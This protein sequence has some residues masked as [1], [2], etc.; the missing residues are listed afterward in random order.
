[1]SPSL[2]GLAAPF[3]AFGR[4]AGKHPVAT[5]AT[6]ATVTHAA[7]VTAVL[8]VDWPEGDP[9]GLR[10]AADAL[11]QLAKKIDDGLVEADEAARLVWMDH[12]GP[13]V[14]AFKN[15]WRGTGSAPSA[16]QRPDGFSGYPPDV[17]DYSRRVAAA[18]RAYADN[19]ETIR[20]VLV[21]MAIQAWVNM[22]FTTMYAWPTAGLGTLAERAVQ[23]Y[24]TSL[25]QSQ[26]KIFGLS[27]QKVVEGAFYYTI[28]SVAYAGI[29]QV[30]KAGVYAASGVRKDQN[31]KD[32]LSF[33]TNAVE[34]AQGFGANMAFNAAGD[35]G[36][37]LPFVTKN[38]WWDFVRRMGGSATYSI[39]DNFEQ[40][41]TENPVPTDWDTWIGKILIHGT[42]AIKPSA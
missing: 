39:V 20:H 7:F 17:A 10:S 31:G 33:S 15:M 36:K 24:F 21:V 12:S 18:C 26:L 29:Q 22:L 14:E 5:T 32:V 6:A 27:V 8:A 35:A 34:F 4:V 11:D 2:A 42:R 13:G 3:A 23:K 38:R 30:L 40:N 37:L 25:A 16:S 19:I 1:M 9:D 41:P 28:D